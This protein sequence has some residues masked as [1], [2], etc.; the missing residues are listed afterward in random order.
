[1]FRGSARGE[2]CLCCPGAGARGRSG[3]VRGFRSRCLPL[4]LPAVPPGPAW[5]GLAWLALAI[6]ATLP[7]FCFGLRRPRRGLGAARVQPRAGDPGPLLLP[8][9]ARDEGGAAGRPARSPTAGRAWSSSRSRSRSP[10][11]ATWCRSTDLVFYALIVWTGG[12]VLTGFGLRRGLAVLALGAAPRL[13]AA[14]A[15]DPLLE[16][17]HRRCSSSPREIGVELRAR[18]PA[19]RSSSTA[20]SSTSGSTSCRWPRPAPGLRYLFPIMSFTYVFAVLYRG[21]LWHKLVLLLS[22]VPLAVMMNAVAHRRHRHPGRPLR[23]RPGRGLPARLRGL[24]GVP[25]LHRPSCSADGHGDAA[26]RRATAGRSARRSTSTSPASAPSSPGCA[27]CRPSRALVAAA[28]LTAALSA[29]WSAGAGARRR[30]AAARALRALP[31]ERSTAGGHAGALEAGRRAR[32]SAPTTTSRRFYRKPGEAERRSTCS[33]PTTSARP[34]ATRIHSPEVCL[35]APAGRSRAIAA[36]DRGAARHRT[37]AVTLNR[38]V[39]QKGL[40]RQLV[41]YWFEGRGRQMTD[42]FAAKFYHPGRQ[43]RPAAAPTAGWCG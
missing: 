26:A 15:A 5:P 3:R 38:A 22:A 13:H 34:T 39:I 20:T 19:S 7:L 28:C 23:H 35:P 31:A 1:M 36:G 37:G 43:R 41:Y 2:F 8:V 25:R 32:C 12:L 24:G 17:Q 11:S 9:P 4:R 18:R 29:A 14:A 33:S 6:L 40:D 16:G 10:R 30:R 42:D 21:P 27:T